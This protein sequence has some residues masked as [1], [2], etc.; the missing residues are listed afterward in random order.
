MPGPETVSPPP[1]R[2]LTPAEVLQL[3][4]MFSARGQLAE[5]E[6]AYRRAMQALPDEAPPC[7]GL[8]LL[9]AKRG[10]NEE[11]L[12][13]L[14]C[15]CALDPQN[16][17]THNNLGR[18]ARACHLPEEALA[19]FRAA[20][21]LA[22]QQPEAHYNSAQAYAALGRRDEALKAWRAALTLAPTLAPAHFQLGLAL[23]EAGDLPAARK[24]LHQAAP[25]HPA[26]SAAYARLLAA[27]DDNEAANTAY[28]LALAL[29]PEDAALHSDAGA[30]RAAA[31]DFEH[32][33]A[34][35]NRAIALEQNLAAAHNNL[36]NAL[37]AQ[38]RW[39]EAG[40][41]YRQALALEPGFAE[42]H[43][44]LGTAALE[45][46][47]AEE[48]LAHFDAALALAPDCAAYHH[49]RGRTLVF[50]GDLDAARAAHEQ[51]MRLAPG[52]PEYF[53]GLAATQK[54]NA[55][56]PAFQAL[57]DF[58]QDI[59]GKPVSAQIS[60][61]FALHRSLEHQG[62]HAEAFAHLLQGNAL[63]RPL[64]PY[65]E[66]RVLAY[67]SRIESVFSPALLSR[68]APVP[69]VPDVPIFILGMPRSGSTLVE[70]ILA[71]HRDVFGAGELM[72]LA[73]TAASLA[74]GGLP[75]PEN[76]LA[77]SAAEFLSA[78]STYRARL[79]ALAPQA[80]RITDKM[81]ANFL[82]IGLLR[83]ILPGA[84]IIHT[85]RDPVDTCLSCF[86]QTF[87]E[88]QPFA[89][90]LG[91]LGRHY[92]AYE[93]LLAHWRAILPEATML[94]VDYET[95]VTD[96]EPQ[97]RRILDYC[98]LGWDPACLDFHTHKRPILTAS[99]SQVRQKL[100][101]HAAG[102]ARP[103]GALLQP[104]LDAL[105]T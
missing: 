72:Y 81:P 44:N 105:K 62:R 50:L 88:G 6:A 1:R 70:Q 97:V 39:A 95:L 51:A 55:D 103:Y 66:A 53:A 34:L 75:Y 71:S 8:G 38:K 60:L 32:A 89:N 16:A 45:L 25:G 99:A 43:G 22:P 83:L 67:F 37:A 21:A 94:E 100:Y 54:L 14:R 31:G 28:A 87:G 49:F 46:L 40:A 4:G 17:E 73:E 86:A 13:W 48:A 3:A 80:R 19:S 18:L 101:T 33:I 102:R 104:L 78:G 92:R 58:A 77:R 20:L 85:R 7:T 64:L 82:H 24:H 68:A 63:R 36:G 41:A 2:P 52:H 11:A 69:A 74:A 29:A 5:A 59:A 61:H 76:A 57:L 79:R 10:A 26:A 93:R 98:E 56:D 96:F 12:H 15:A 91:E 84:R 35:F 42:V 90:E 47:R 9:L 30:A 27:L 23:Q 65:D